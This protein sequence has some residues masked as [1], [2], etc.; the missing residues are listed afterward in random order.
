MWYGGLESGSGQ[1]YRKRSS[2]AIWRGTDRI[3]PESYYVWGGMWLNNASR[4]DACQR[5][6]RNIMTISAPFSL[7]FP[8]HDLASI[9]HTFHA[10]CLS[11][12][13]AGTS[14]STSIVKKKRVR[15]LGSLSTY[16]PITTKV[17][18][19]RP[20]FTVFKAIVLRRKR[21]LVLVSQNLWFHERGNL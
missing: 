10:M 15:R 19:M 6:L 8:L 3:R 17:L 12:C 21:R 14:R 2:K 4:Y 9:S 1:A 11:L 5:G 13:E 18:D 7:P 16:Q 20:G